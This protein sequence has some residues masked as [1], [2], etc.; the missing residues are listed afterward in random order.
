MG[1]AQH[2]DAVRCVRYTLA[3][4]ANDDV[5]ASRTDKLFCFAVVQRSSMWRMIT[6]KELR[7]AFLSARYESPIF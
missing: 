7:T 1:V 6:H 5:S 2:H 3:Q 4:L